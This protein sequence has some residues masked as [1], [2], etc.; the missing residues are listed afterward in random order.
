MKLEFKVFNLK[1]PPCFCDGKSTIKRG[2]GVY[3]RFQRACVKFSRC[4]VY[5]RKPI[6][7]NKQENRLLPLLLLFLLDIVKAIYS[8]SHWLPTKKAMFALREGKRA[9]RRELTKLT[10]KRDFNGLVYE[11]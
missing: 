8:H 10:E 3:I 1:E 4:K 2:R 9:K 11:G 5:L 7:E 6:R